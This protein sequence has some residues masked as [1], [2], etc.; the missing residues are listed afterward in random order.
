MLVTPG[1]RNRL[2][3]PSRQIQALKRPHLIEADLL[4]DLAVVRL[5]VGVAEPGTILRSGIGLRVLRASL[6]LLPARCGPVRITGRLLLTTSSL[7]RTSFIHGID[8]T[9]L[10]VAFS[11]GSLADDWCHH[12][13]S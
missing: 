6:A 4:D 7:P 10:A 1:I 12:T 5:Q 3:W 13:L 9:T 11:S 2:M 8:G